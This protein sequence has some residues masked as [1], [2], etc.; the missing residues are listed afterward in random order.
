MIELL[1]DNVG[2]IDRPKQSLAP[3]PSLPLFPSVNIVGRFSD[4]SRDSPRLFEPARD[5]AVGFAQDRL[6]PRRMVPAATRRVG[7][8]E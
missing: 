3:A 7:P 1:A 5:Y 8:R 6:R 2:P 4:L